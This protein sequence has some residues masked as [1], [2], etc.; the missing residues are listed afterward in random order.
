[1]ESW[2]ATALEVE[3]YPF[4]WLLFVRVICADTGTP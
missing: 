3:P 1:L 2:S 4:E